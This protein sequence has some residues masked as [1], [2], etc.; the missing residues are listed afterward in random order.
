MGENSY[1]GR[2]QGRGP[3]RRRGRTFGVDGNHGR[4]LR[5][6]RRRGEQGNHGA[7]L[8][9]GNEPERRGGRDQYGAGECRSILRLDGRTLRHDHH[10]EGDGRENRLR[11]PSGQPVRH[12]HFPKAPH[13][14][15][16]RASARRRRR[17][18][19]GQGS[20]HGARRQVRGLVRLRLRRRGPDRGRSSGRRRIRPGGIEIPHLRRNGYGHAGAR[21]HLCER[22]REQGQD[23]RLHAH[24]RRL[25]PKSLRDRLRDR[26]G[27]YRQLQRQPLDDHP[28]IQAA[29]R[30]HGRRAH[31]NAGDGA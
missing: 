9:R 25:Q 13:D 21:R 14:G 8:L 12:G 15:I 2:A 3:S 6:F 4:N 7:R 16:D 29:P 30:H 28:E 5:R 1:S 18:R 17:R 11:V 31:G 19:N 27:V 24:H 26:P 20:R 23:A 22:R 10:G